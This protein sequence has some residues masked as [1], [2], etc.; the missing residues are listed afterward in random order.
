[1][2]ILTPRCAL[3]VTYKK[4]PTPTPLFFAQMYL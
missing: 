1:M 4:G 2:K 3:I